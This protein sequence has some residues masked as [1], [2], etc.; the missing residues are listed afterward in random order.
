M[1]IVYI[2]MFL[3]IAIVSY[4]WVGGIDN[5]QNNHPNYKGEDFLEEDNNKNSKA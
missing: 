5:M 3:F 4:L 2:A 1:A